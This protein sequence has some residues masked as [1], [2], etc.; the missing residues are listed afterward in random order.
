MV[1]EP[2]GQEERVA[3]AEVHRVPANLRA[4]LAAK[5]E[6][7]HVGP[8]DDR[9]LQVLT[10]LRRSRIRGVVRRRPLPH[11]E[12]GGDRHGRLRVDL[13]DDGRGGR[14]VDVVVL[15]GPRR[16]ER[17]LR[18]AELDE[19]RGGR[20]LAK[21]DVGDGFAERG[22][23]VGER[24]HPVVDDRDRVGA[25]AIDAERRQAV[26]ALDA[27]LPRFVIEPHDG[28]AARTLGE[29]GHGCPEVAQGAGDPRV[30]A[31]G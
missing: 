27:Q 11:R 18:H 17:L 30:G 23:H 5:K 16:R 15:E 6:R 1:I 3:F 2:L 26:E 22:D 24:D 10:T 29:S 31:L 9:R 19:Q 13:D 21:Q 25:A 7:V 8:L 12:L 20:R 28:L 4:E 14:R